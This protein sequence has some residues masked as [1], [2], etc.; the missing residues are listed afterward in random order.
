MP[1]LG[2]TLRTARAEKRL[3][4]AQVAERTK[5]P[6]E[7]LQVLESDRYVDLPDDVYLKGAIRNYA[8]FLGLNPTETLGLYRQARPEEERRVPLSTAPTTRTI[9]VIPTTIGVLVLVILILVA[10]VALHVIVL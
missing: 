3:K 6:L 2:E 10:L 7:R 8:L 9:A 4:L 5:I 1:T